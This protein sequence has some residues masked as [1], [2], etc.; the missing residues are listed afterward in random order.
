MVFFSLLPS[1][2]MG[3]KKFGA[4]QDGSL[5]AAAVHPH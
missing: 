4:E 2:K 5:R 3:P 1:L